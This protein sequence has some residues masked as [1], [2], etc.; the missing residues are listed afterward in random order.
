MAQ[1]DRE[2]D[3]ERVEDPEPDTEERRAAAK[4]IEREWPKDTTLTEMAHM[5]DYSRQHF[6][7]TIHSHFRYVEPEPEEV[8]EDDETVEV[9]K[10]ILDNPQAREAFIRGYEAG[11]LMGKAN[12][13]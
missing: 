12:A 7:N 9:P 2:K 6:V 4:I 8:F 3:L 13:V 5:S 1:V 11:W 10:A